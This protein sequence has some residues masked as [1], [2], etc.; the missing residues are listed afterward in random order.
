MK[1]FVIIL[2]ATF[3]FVGCVKSDRYSDLKARCDSL[4][5]RDSTNK[6]ETYLFVSQLNE[7]QKSD[8]IKSDSISKLNIIIDSLKAKPMMSEEQF[9]KIYKYESLYK[10][11]KIV[12]NNS[13]QKKFFWGWSKR[14]FEQ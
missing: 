7:L 6:S 13:S 5:V 1:K 8:S 11:Y 3:I 14:V 2:L 9:L 10:Y 4:L 12:I